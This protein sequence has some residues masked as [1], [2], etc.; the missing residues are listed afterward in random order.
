MALLD[1]S[2]KLKARQVPVASI[3][4]LTSKTA[5]DEGLEVVVE[6]G[7][8]TFDALLTEISEYFISK[9]T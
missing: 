9:D 7:V 3:G 2:G 5:E 8:S 1:A 4:P 6:P